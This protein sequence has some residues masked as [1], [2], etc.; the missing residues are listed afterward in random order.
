[1]RNDKLATGDVEVAATSIE[2][3]SEAETP[4]FPV[5]DGIEVSEELRLTHRYVDLRRPGWPTT[6]GCAPG[7]PRSSGGME[8]TASSTSRPRC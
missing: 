6:S 1:M 4:P 3:L 8:R 2:V 7:S 5:E